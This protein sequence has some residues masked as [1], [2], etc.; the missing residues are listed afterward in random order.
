M[1][2][3][4]GY[5]R[6]TNLFSKRYPGAKVQGN[7][8]NSLMTDD[9]SY[10]IAME[11]LISHEKE[12]SLG[13]GERELRAKLLAQFSCRRQIHGES[14]ELVEWKELRK[15]EGEVRFKIAQ[16]EDLKLHILVE[17]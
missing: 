2:W 9:P 12:K 3:L 7:L 15:E 1:A 5:T 17:G 11:I 6:N 13:N 4:L 8:L 16:G 14:K 10:P